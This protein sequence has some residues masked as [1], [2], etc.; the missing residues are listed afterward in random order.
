MPGPARGVLRE[1]PSASIAHARVCEGRGRRG[2]GAPKRARSRKRW[3]RPRE[4]YG[5]D[6]SS[7]TRSTPRI[8]I[9]LILDRAQGRYLSA[10]RSLATVRRLLLPALQVNIARGCWRFRW[11]RSTM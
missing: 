5:R 2:Y 3:T 10:V 7:P 1:E 11:R 4:A 6:R 9:V 8:E